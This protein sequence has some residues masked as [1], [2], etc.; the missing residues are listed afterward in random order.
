MEVPSY[1]SNLNEV[2]A[3]VTDLNEMDLLSFVICTFTALTKNHLHL[4]SGCIK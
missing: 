3:K 1:Q 4:E 2:F